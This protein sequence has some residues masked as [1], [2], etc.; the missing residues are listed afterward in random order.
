MAERVIVD[1]A[2]P[3]KADPPIRPLYHWSCDFKA[4]EYRWTS[5][6]DFFALRDQRCFVVIDH[7]QAPDDADMPILSH[8]F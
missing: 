2:K 7:G 3:V 8:T 5:Y 1:P 6:N 4:P